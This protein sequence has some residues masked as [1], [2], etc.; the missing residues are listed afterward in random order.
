MVG[1]GVNDAPS[2][3]RATVGISLGKIGSATAI[4]ASDIVFLQDDLDQIPWLLEKA[5]KTTRILK[6]NL[7][8]ACS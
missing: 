6:Q 1:D 2:L 7:T 4:D 5:R 3:S 8:L